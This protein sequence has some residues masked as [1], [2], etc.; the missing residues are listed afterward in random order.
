MIFKNHRF[1]WKKVF[2][3]AV[4]VGSICGISRT[5]YAENVIHNE[6]LE[7]VYRLYNPN[8]GEHFYTMD[9]LDDDSCNIR[10][11]FL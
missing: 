2:L 9:A 5:A 6:D 3:L 11:A 4:F 8:S 7:V 10:T 1:K